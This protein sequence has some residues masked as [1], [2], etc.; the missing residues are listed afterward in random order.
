MAELTGQSSSVK[1]GEISHTDVLRELCSEHCEDGNEK[2]SRVTGVSSN[3]EFW[4]SRVLETIRKL[5]GMSKNVHIAFPVDDEDETGNRSIDKA[6]E[7][8]TRLNTVCQTLVMGTVSVAHCSYR[9][10]TRTNTPPAVLSCFW[11]EPSYN[12]IVPLVKRKTMR[13]RMGRM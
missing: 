13:V 4:I 5:E 7:T 6:Q 8:L 11:Q 3:G 10:T 12:G 2:A 9:W 1:S